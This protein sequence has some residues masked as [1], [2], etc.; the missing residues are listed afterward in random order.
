MSDIFSENTKYTLCKIMTIVSIILI[1][2]LA[3]ELSVYAINKIYNYYYGYTWIHKGLKIWR[4][5]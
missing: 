2:I 4:F 1:V 3:F 5:K